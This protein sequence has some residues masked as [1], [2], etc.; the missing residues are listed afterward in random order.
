[1]LSLAKRYDVNEHLRVDRAQEAHDQ[2]LP[3]LRRVVRSLGR[4]GDVPVF[5]ALHDELAGVLAGLEAA[6]RELD[7]VLMSGDRGGGG[8]LALG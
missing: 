4:R 6:A 3:R 5:R 1:M 8:A 7:V 2:Q